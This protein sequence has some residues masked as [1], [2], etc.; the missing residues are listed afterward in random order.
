M[1]DSLSKQ[2]AGLLLDIGAVGFTPNDPITFKSGLVSPVYVDNRRLPFH[3]KAWHAV[4]D[5]FRVL[6]REHGIAFQAVAGIE[7][8]GIPHS[9]AL[10]YAM[11]MPSLFVRK[12]PKEHGKGQRI[13]GGDV[14]GKRVLLV[15]DLVTTG[16]SCLAGVDALRAEGALVTDCLCIVSYGFPEAVDAFDKAEVRLHTL[17]PFSLIVGQA[18]ERQAFD[19]DTLAAI[20][21]WADAPYTWESSS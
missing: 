21:R 6:I 14:R 2:I 18:H 19:G 5:G 17:A 1:M 7:A 16:G 11:D 10:G 12:Q 20:Q 15:E 8:A 3:P 13:E 9:A 4:I